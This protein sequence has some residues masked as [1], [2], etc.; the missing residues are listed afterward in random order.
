[1]NRGVV[2][3]GRAGGPDDVEGVAA[4]KRGELLAGVRERGVRAR[5]DAVR[6]GG[7]ADESL[8]CDEPRLAR[9]GRERRGGVVVEINHRG[10]R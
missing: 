8:A 5:A 1:M 6:A 4:E 3:L 2:G 7:I 9:D 10:G